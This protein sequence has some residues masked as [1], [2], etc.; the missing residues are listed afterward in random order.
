MSFVAART[1]RIW[2]QSHDSCFEPGPRLL[3][4]RDRC[5][6]LVKALVHFASTRVIVS[7]A[8]ILLPSRSIAAPNTVPPLRAKRLPQ[9][10]C[11]V[12][13]DEERLQTHVLKPQ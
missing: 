4:A 11:I 5:I 7:P 12:V 1:F 10:R 8:S 9:R 2:A 3:S 6:R 13:L